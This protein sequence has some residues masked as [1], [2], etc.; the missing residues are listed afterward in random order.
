MTDKGRELLSQNLLDFEFFAFTDEGI[1]YGA[2][3]TASLQTSGSVDEYIRR[4]PLLEAGQMKDFKEQKDF[5]TFLYSVPTGR[6][7]LPEFTTNFDDRVDISA[8]RR[9]F[10][11]IL[12]LTA[13]KR[14]VTKNPISVVARGT[15]PKKTRSAMLRDY[16]LEQQVSETKKR[17][18]KGLNV[19]GQPIG[20]DHVMLNR[21]TVL[22]TTTGLTLPTSNFK[23]ISSTTTKATSVKSEVEVV[24]GL[25]R[26]KIDMV[27]ESSEGSVDDPSGYLIEVYESGSDGSLTYL[28]EENV[29]DVLDDTVKK[30]GF[31]QDFFLDVDATNAEI[32]SEARREVRRLQR[33][34][35]AEF[36]RL[37]KRLTRKVR[38]I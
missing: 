14:T 19:T 13:K 30:E 9:Y 26:V 17:L 21:N 6:K 11:D 3:L 12:I 27:L 33:Q 15:I 5:A 2:A 38:D 36:R 8:K 32:I 16:S 31:E 34:R 7:T 1:D 20:K 25:S 22:N 29:V 37:E 18:T 28:F 35:E 23:Q 24:T 4:T 10:I